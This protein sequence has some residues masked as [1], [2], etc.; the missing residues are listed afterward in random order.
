VLRHIPI[1]P[2]TGRTLIGGGLSSRAPRIPSICLSAGPRLWLSDLS[3][4]F[5]HIRR[6]RSRRMRDSE[7]K[8]D[9]ETPLLTLGPMLL[10]FCPFLHIELPV[11]RSSRSLPALHL[12]SVFF[13]YSHRAIA[14]RKW[15]WLNFW[16]RICRGFRLRVSGLV[17]TWESRFI[18]SGD[19]RKSY[20]FIISQDAQKPLWNYATRPESIVRPSHIVKVQTWANDVD[21]FKSYYRLISLECLY[22]VEHPMTIDIARCRK[23]VGES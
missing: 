7:N 9:A 16:R 17:M 15:Y 8:L 1:L 14:A 21:Q 5:S 23:S 22:P 10:N 18:F 13:L 4:S 2:F 3:F 12:A 19:G 6:I 11:C 20:E